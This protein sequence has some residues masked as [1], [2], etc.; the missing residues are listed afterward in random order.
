MPVA[1]LIREE[2]EI[3]GNVSVELNGNEV[4][5]KAGSKVLKRE[6]SFPGIEIKIENGKVVVESTFPR[7]N[8]TA[9]VGTYRAHIQNMI[10]GVSEGFEYRLV[11]RYA[12]FPMKVTFKGNLVTID[13]FLG[14]KHPRTAKV[15][16][17]VTVKVNGE[18]VIVSGT[19]KEFVGQTAANIEQATKVKGRDTRIFQDGIYIVEKA[20]KV[21]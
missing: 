4:A 8:Q 12:H 17:G 15:M 14:E 3:P 13:N 1:A 11:I 20:G 21:L 2:I 6:L 7:K 9:M 19:N 5:V 18:E 10:K 16:E